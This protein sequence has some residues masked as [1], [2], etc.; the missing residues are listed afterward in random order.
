MTPA[1]NR[2]SESTG[3]GHTWNVRRTRFILLGKFQVFVTTVTAFVFPED[4][5]CARSLAYFHVTRSPIVHREAGWVLRQSGSRRPLRLSSKLPWPRAR[6]PG[7]SPLPALTPTLARHPE[8]TTLRHTGPS[9]VLAPPVSGPGSSQEP[10]Q[11]SPLSPHC[12]GQASLLVSRKPPGRAACFSVATLAVPSACDTLPSPP[13]SHHAK[14]TSSVKTALITQLKRVTSWHSQLH[15]HL[16]P[17]L[18]LPSA[19]LSVYNKN[20][21]IYST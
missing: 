20:L 14:V 19:S 7:P 21:L 10:L 13:S 3:L 6:A 9:W 16:A 1:G 15:L 17:C 2:R 18:P 12:S 5:P 4:L 8:A 11:P